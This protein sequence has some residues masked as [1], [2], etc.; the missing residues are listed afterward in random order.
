MNGLENKSLVLH[1]LNLNKEITGKLGKVL[2]QPNRDALLEKIY[3]ETL[4]DEQL[5]PLL[6]SGAL[7]VEEIAQIQSIAR[8]RVQKNI[9]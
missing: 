5:V 2:N 8:Q 6:M 1:Y 3:Q 9:Q 7:S 4:T